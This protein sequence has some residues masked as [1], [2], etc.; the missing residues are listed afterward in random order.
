V[1][2]FAGKNAFITG[3]AHGIGLSLARALAARGVN[4]GL[5]DIDA[6]DLELARTEISKIGVRALAL[7]LDVSD[8]AAVNGARDTFLRE[9]GD[10]HL[11]FNNAGVL[12]RWTPLLEISQEKLDWM[13]GVNLFGM[14]NSL[15]AF[16]PAMIAHGKGGHIVNTSSIAGLQTNPFFRNVP[17]RMTKYAITGMTECLNEELGLREAGIGVSVFCPALITTTLADS[18]KRRPQRFGGPFDGVTSTPQGASF[19]DVS[20]AMSSDDAARIVI[21]GIE[22]DVFFIFSHEDCRAWMEERQ[23]LVLAGFDHLAHYNRGDGRA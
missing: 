11:L 10:P 15:R 16:V 13:F 7:P 3:A 2:E 21:D 17:Y 18:P 19:R 22:Q 6:A 9:L 1:K 8:Q 14:L 23:Q 4:I 5:A 20:F 12:L